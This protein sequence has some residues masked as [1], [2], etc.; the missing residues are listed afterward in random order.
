MNDWAKLVSK[1]YKEKSK[2]NKNYKLMHAMKDAK[3]VYYK[4]GK[5]AKKRSPK[6]KSNSKRK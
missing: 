6:N 4:G 2:T 3:K 1:I 5:T